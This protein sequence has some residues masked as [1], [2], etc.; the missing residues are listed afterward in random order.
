LNI[1]VFGS[2]IV[3]SYWNGAATYYR[4]IYKYLARRGHRIIFAEP[5]AYG[6]Q[7]HR[8]QGDYSYVESIVYQPGADVSRML[9]WAANADVIIKHS[10]MGKDDD[11]LEARI[12]ELQRA[13][14]VFF[15]DVDAPATIGRLHA[16]PHDSFRA[17]I[18]QYD[19]IFTYGGGPRVRDEYLAFGARAYY[20]IYNGLDP[21]TH[22]PVPSDPELICDVAFLGNRL[23]DREARVEELFFKA[24]ELASDKQFLLGGEGWG[25]K[26]K[27]SNVRWIGHV[28]TNDHNRVNCSAGMVMNINRSS[29]ADFGFSP[30]TRVFEVAGAGACMLCDDWPGIS[31]CFEPEKEILVI[32]TAQDV[33]NALRHYDE[34]ERRRIGH[35][36]YIRALRDHTYAQRAEQAEKAFLECIHRKQNIDGAARSQDEPVEEHA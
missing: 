19:A 32:R 18:P 14:A 34:T 13:N 5:D 22:H 26:R 29:M 28:G 15:W 11:V 16:N 6:R 12:P 3:S 2:S 9:E 35:A 21:D 1:F 25:D 30:P 20:S 4:G 7:E 24:A 23:P 10:G 8:D 36:F 31:D 27:P 33:V 17:A